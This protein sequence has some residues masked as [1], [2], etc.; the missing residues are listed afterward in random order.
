MRFLWY[1]L[2]TTTVA[3]QF[4]STENYM[5]HTLPAGRVLWHLTVSGMDTSQP[6][7]F[8]PLRHVAS[9]PYCPREEHGGSA[10]SRRPRVPRRR[11]EGKQTS[12]GTPGHTPGPSSRYTAAAECHFLRYSC[13]TVGDFPRRLRPRSCHAGHKKRRPSGR[14]HGDRTP[15]PPAPLQ[16]RE[17]QPP[18]ALSTTHTWGSDERFVR[19]CLVI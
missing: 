19:I 10:H 13:T 14:R 9:W 6:L 1:V 3:T 2:P 4:R 8:L 16:R 15:R 17:A 5:L 12:Y 18:L 11:V 7:I